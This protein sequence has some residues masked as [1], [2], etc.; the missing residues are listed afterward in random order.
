MPDTVARIVIEA[1]TA[2]F[3]YPHFLIGR[4]PSF[5]MPP[6]STIFGLVAAA[7][8]DWPDRP[9][10]F[11]YLFT[12][13]SRCSD[14][15]HQH[16]ISRTSGDF[17]GKPQDPLWRPPEPVGRIKPKPRIL[18]KTTEATVQP[19]LRDFLFDVRLELF[20]DPPEL[21]DAFRSPAFAISLGRSQDLAA[22]RSVEVLRL[23]HDVS[24][25]IETT[26]LP[27]SLRP[28][29][30]WGITCH[31][32]TYVGPAPR[33]VAVF[34]PYILLRERVY[35]GELAARASPQMQ[36]IAGQEDPRWAVDPTSAEDRGGRRLLW[37]HE[38]NPTHPLHASAG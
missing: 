22:I 31:M 20:L 8:G 37:F 6:P 1:P 10:R 9:I 26:L 2:S 24:G 28:R 27:L 11:A 21:A 38:I 36:S 23:D 17:P 25:Y 3:R 14:L 5:D 16:V 18:Q 7:L 34:D 15:E 29:L 30:P 13:K 4:Q 19:H 32:P 12:S 33:R 35:V